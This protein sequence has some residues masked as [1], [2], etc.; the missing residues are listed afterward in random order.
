MRQPHG[1]QRHRER[2]ER[3]SMSIEI[4]SRSDGRVIYTAENAQDVRGAVEDANLW[5]Q[6]VKPFVV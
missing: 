4:R 3:N 6:R 1:T 2:P 5:Y